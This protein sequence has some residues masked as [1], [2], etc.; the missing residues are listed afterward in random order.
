[1]LTM[2]WKETDRVGKPVTAAV[3]CKKLGSSHWGVEPVFV[4]NFEPFCLRSFIKVYS[5]VVYLALLQVLLCSCLAT[6]DGSSFAVGNMT[7]NYLVNPLGLDKAK[8]RFS[9]EV[10]AEDETTRGLSQVDYRILIGNTGAADGSVWDS[11]IV[12]SNA[13]IQLR[14]GG[15]SLKSGTMYTWAVSV[16]VKQLLDDES[17]AVNT[18]TSP[19]AT[20]STGM[21]SQSEWTGSFIGMPPAHGLLLS[22]Q[23]TDCPWFRKSFALPADALETGK[24]TALLYVASIGTASCILHP[25][26]ASVCSLEDTCLW[27]QQRHKAPSSR[28]VS[29]PC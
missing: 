26:S 12:A 5:M 23:S 13:S 17:W 25:A 16:T 1:M 11:G 2:A 4:A 21:F 24:P 7:T 18:A 10:V 15:P 29:W 28:R 20:F 19:L 27:N 3:L 22:A 8:P 9:Y 6:A 14:Y